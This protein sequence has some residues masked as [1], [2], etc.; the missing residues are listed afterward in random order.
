MIQVPLCSRILLLRLSVMA[1]SQL[2][3]SKVSLSAFTRAR[4]MFWTEATIEAQAA[5]AGHEDPR[6]DC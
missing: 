6:E 4:L 5:Q 2:T 3:R 1:R